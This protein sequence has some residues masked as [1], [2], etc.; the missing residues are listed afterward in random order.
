MDVRR[1]LVCSARRGPVL[2]LL[3]L[4]FSGL[5]QSTV[6]PALPV[7]EASS[8]TMTSSTTSTTC[9]Y[10]ANPSY[11][12]PGA[13]WDRAVASAPT[14]RRMVLNPAS[15]VGSTVDSVYIDAV[16]AAR[17][18]G[19]EVLGYVS[20]RYGVRPA[21]DVASETT[22]YADWYGVT[23]IFL[24][25]AATSTAALPYYADA[26]SAV[27]ARGGTVALNF[28]TV[29]AEEYL[30]FT[31]VA[32]TFEGTYATYRAATFPSWTRSY[33]PAR[34]WH[35]VY[36]ASKPAMVSALKKARLAGVGNVYVTDDDGANPWDTLP[37]YWTQELQAVVS[38]NAGTC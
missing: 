8:P 31:D 26:A 12:Y 7:A 33:A 16:A 35:L 21:E 18:A 1:L 10:G 34:F 28:G 13:T 22:R 29:P 2:A 15:G 20:T 37:S 4:L 9:Q 27:H 3:L 23:S 14:L 24:D 25:E 36:A 11:F 5:P 6:A 17:A 38:G 30:T 19:I 32:V